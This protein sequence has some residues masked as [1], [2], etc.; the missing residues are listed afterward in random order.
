[1]LPIST[2]PSKAILAQLDAVESSEQLQQQAKAI[3]DR[4]DWI[5]ALALLEA[6]RDRFP[7]ESE[8]TQQIQAYR[9]EWDQ[10]SLMLQNQLLLIELR[11]LV[12]SLP[13][14]EQLAEGAP[15][16]QLLKTRILIWRSYLESKIADLNVCVRQLEQVNPWLARRCLRM[17]HRIE[18]D[19][20]N[21]E[22]LQGLNRRILAIE[23][24]AK[25]RAA[26]RT[27][28]IRAGRVEELLA[29]AEE[30]R[31]QG[32]LVEAKAKV[33]EALREDPHNFEAHSQLVDL[34]QRLQQ[35]A[36]VLSRLGDRLYRSQQTGA[37]VAVWEAALRLDP[38]RKAV[39]DRIQ[40]AR[41]V[42]QKLDAIRTSTEAPPGPAIQAPAE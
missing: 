22:I 30:E 6:G 25:R 5:N 7:G 3:H 19:T 24:N 17:A 42:L 32:A 27:Q 15:G 23:Q 18:P 10:Q 29:A 39:E 4:G 2:Q 33:D 13:L 14:L 41:T 34:Q 12:D 20:A 28:R 21:E 16:N 38:E 1:M 37:A 35:Q 36:E 40:R 31:Q 11:R 8:I 26:E 9:L